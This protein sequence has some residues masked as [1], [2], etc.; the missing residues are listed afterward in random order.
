MQQL[1][2]L[3]TTDLGG[4]EITQP[5]ATEMACPEPEGVMEQ[6]AAYL[7]ALPT[8]VRYQISGPSLELQTAEGTLV[9]TFTRT[10]E[11]K[12]ACRAIRP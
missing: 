1:H 9:A 3:F 4:I 5:A 6:E 11:P 8:A 7:A 10:S 12:A 2:R